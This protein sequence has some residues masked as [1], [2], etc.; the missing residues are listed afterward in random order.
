MAVLEELATELESYTET[1]VDLEFVDVTLESGSGDVININEDV[2][3][4]LRV[5]N[6]GP[7]TLTDVRLRIEGKSGAKV[8]G[9]G[10]LAEYD[11]EA[12]ANTID[13]IQG[14]N[15]NSLYDTEVLWVK[16][17]PRTKPAGTD[18]VQAFVEDYNADIDHLLVSHT[19][20]SE[21]PSGTFESAVED[22]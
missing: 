20:T 8:K 22:D 18:L 3:F 10:A 7:L 17:P 2:M 14:H 11:R 19:R 12:F 21:T 15:G 1:Y 6:R 4:K 5:H 16:A 13:R 9:N